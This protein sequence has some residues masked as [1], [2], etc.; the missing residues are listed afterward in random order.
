[1]HEIKHFRK[2]NAL[3]FMNA[4]TSGNVIVKYNTAIK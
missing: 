3:Y 1:M 2:L 4:K